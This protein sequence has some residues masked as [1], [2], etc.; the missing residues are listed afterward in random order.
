MT[1]NAT[2]P[3]LPLASFAIQVTV[4]SP[5]GK[6]LPDFGVQIGPYVTS[7]LSVATGDAYFTTAPFAVVA[8]TDITFG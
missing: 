4:V 2:E 7:I 1:R 8:S 6:K 5:S 3:W